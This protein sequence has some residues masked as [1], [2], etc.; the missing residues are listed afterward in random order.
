[1]PSDNYWEFIDSSAMVKG[2]PQAFGELC[3]PVRRKFTTSHFLEEM[4]MTFQQQQETSCSPNKQKHSYNKDKQERKK[5]WMGT[6]LTSTQHGSTP[7]KYAI[8]DD[9]EVC[10]PGPTNRNLRA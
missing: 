10:V 7:T 1:V 4:T 5:T 2:F 9:S 8:L 3:H 6:L